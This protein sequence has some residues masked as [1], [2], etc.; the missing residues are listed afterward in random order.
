M[1]LLSRAR[2]PLPSWHEGAAKEAIIGF[3]NRVTTSGHPEFIPIA[4]RIAVFD[5]DGTLCPEMPVYAQFAFTADRARAM[6]PAHPEWSGESPFKEVLAGDMIGALKL[7][8]GVFAR[9]LAATYAGMTTDEFERDVRTWMATARHPKTGRPYTEMVYQPMLELIAFLQA[10]RFRVYLV[11]ASG[12]DFLR[13]W[14]ESVYS[15]PR[16]Q[17]IGSSIRLQF[18]SRDGKPALV[19]LPVLE[20]YDEGDEKPVAIHHFIGRRPVFAFGNADGDIAMLRWVA[21]GDGPH[22]CGLLHHTDSDR[23][24]AYEA[25]DPALPIGSAK[26]A[27][28]MAPGEGWIVVD[29]KK[30]WRIIFSSGF[31]P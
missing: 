10:N 14:I 6:A 13:P 16:E 22:F 4:E 9:V 3:V 23:E 29:M 25:Y 15:I 1:S 7:G 24:W 8:I 21:S 5:H 20:V 2:D 17:V 11:S 30:D 31:R 18:A 12:I 28:A 26:K 27:L 19:R